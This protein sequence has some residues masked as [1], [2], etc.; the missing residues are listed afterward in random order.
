MVPMRR[1]G[2]VGVGRAWIGGLIAVPAVLFAPPAA[3]AV[4]SLPMTVAHYG[5]LCRQSG[6]VLATY[7]TGGV[8]TVQCQWSGHGRTECKVGAGVVNVCGIACQSTACLK[9][10][11]ARYTPKWPLQGGPRSAALP[12]MPGGGTLAPAN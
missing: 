9:D 4:E 7:L 10:N 11:P 1:V 8:G 12:T 3:V 2:K 5:D 6:G